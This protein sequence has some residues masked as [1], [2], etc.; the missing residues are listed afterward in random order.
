VRFTLTEGSLAKR[1]NEATIGLKP[2]CR[3]QLSTNARRKTSTRARRL[4]FG[5][6]VEDG[7]HLSLDSSVYAPFDFLRLLCRAGPFGSRGGMSM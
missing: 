3:Q 2:A 5:R 6:S 4:V 1:L 7:W